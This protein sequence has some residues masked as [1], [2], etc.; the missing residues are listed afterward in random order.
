[1]KA[2]SK[3]RV[4]HLVVVGELL[5]LE[6]GALGADHD[7]KL[8]AHADRLG[9]AVGVAAVV[10]EARLA[11]LTL[12]PGRISAEDFGYTILSAIPS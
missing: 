12:A 11:P 2:T 3:Q 9:D 7:V 6:D 8:A 10:Y 5:A 4:G 1:M